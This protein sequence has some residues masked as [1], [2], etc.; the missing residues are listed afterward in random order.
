MINKNNDY[1]FVVDS[2]NRPL[3]PTKVN[4]GWYLIRKKRA[5]QIKKFPMTIKL[6][7]EVSV[8]QDTSQFIVGIDD[9][10]YARL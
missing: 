4:K 8:S 5:I 9:V 10:I 7:K 2:S 6:L 1:C 3:P